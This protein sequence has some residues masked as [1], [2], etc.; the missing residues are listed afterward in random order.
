VPIAHTGLPY[1]THPIAAGS[2]DVI[3]ARLDRIDVKVAAVD[4][5][6]GRPVDGRGCYSV[7]LATWSN[8]HVSVYCWYLA[9][10]PSRTVHT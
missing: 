6:G 7:R 1:L 10:L 9:S 4:G 2:E 8:C 3:G 5:V